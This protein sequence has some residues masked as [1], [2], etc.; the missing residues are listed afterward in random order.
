VKYG[1]IISFTSRQGDL[2]SITLPEGSYFFDYTAY[3]PSLNPKA[4]R[5][6]SPGNI[7]DSRNTLFWI[8]HL[9]LNQDTSHKLTFQAARF[10]GTYVILFRAVSSDGNILYGLNRF[11]IE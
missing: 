4:A 8:D 5:Y 7:P 1:G 9:E 11:D 2:A 10:P 6:T 3:Q